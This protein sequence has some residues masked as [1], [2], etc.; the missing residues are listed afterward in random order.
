MGGGQ[1]V[2]EC[3]RVSLHA[4]PPPLDEDDPGSFPPD[5]LP[6]Q[7][8]T[9]PR[10]L[11]LHDED[12]AQ[13]IIDTIAEK[14]GAPPVY[15]EGKLWRYDGRGIWEPQPDAD[16]RNLVCSWNGTPIVGKDG[17]AKTRKGKPPPMFAGT[18]RAA[19]TALKRTVDRT[20]DLTFFDSSATGVMFRDRFVRV[21]ETGDVVECAP[22]PE[23]RATFRIDEPYPENPLAP[24]E[25]YIDMMFR[26]FGGE[27]DDKLGKIAAIQEWFGLALIGKPT[28]DAAL[29][30][31]GPERSGKSVTAKVG[32]GVFP[33]SV[34]AAISLKSLD[35]GS[36]AGG[37]AEYYL[38]QLAGVR[39]NADLDLP[40]GQF[41]QGENFKKIV[42]GEPLSGRF[43]G[44]KAFTFTPRAAMLFA[45]ESLPTPEDK[46]R[47]F[48]RRWLVIRYRNQVDPRDVV[49]NYERIILAKERALIAAWFIQGAAASIKRGGFVIPPSVA[50]EIPKWVLETDYT[51]QWCAQFC[52]PAPNMPRAQW[53]TASSF[54]NRFR[55]WSASNGHGTK[56][57]N[58]FSKDLK[59]CLASDL[60]YEDR[61]GVTRWGYRYETP[62]IGPEKPDDIGWKTK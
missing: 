62:S 42:T 20:Q 8:H 54:Y 61:N 7:P 44:G 6:V 40:G 24:P 49:Q 59:R 4:V 52:I 30:L 32:L 48:F 47:G 9:G 12:V 29:Y 1:P 58:T 28:N 43:P 31:L 51:A 23:C 11:S 36:A 41:I 16:I 5:A 38:A 35:P 22:S 46:N 27:D 13:A 26:A 15:A 19:E 60:C 53:P 37:K 56:S 25:E 45:G 18:Q 21:T 39:I 14:T 55:E 10:L 33:P 3:L 34:R 2:R 50:A 17:L 57:S